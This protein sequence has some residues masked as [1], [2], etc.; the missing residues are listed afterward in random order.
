MPT[1]RDKTSPAAFEIR[2]GVPEGAED[3][4]AQL[5]WQAFRSK[6]STALGDQTAAIR[7]LRDSLANDRFL[8]AV[9]GT[10]VLGAM[11]YHHDKRSALAVG[12][13]SMV[14]N[15]SVWSA[16]IRLLALA[17]LERTPTPGELLLDG[18]SVHPDARGRGIGTALLAEARALAHDYGY[19]RIRLAVVDTNPR[20]RA[21]YEKVGFV[22]TATE[23]HP[24]IGAF[25]GFSSSTEF[26]LA[27]TEAPEDQQ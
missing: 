22:A 25:Y 4:V 5:Y 21:L 24:L 14:A 15:Y 11:G 20:A 18:I 12:W 26:E 9:D 17:P 8:C 16:P 1:E 3:E 23:H 27:I 19:Q 13:T 2:R 10:R 6:L 7:L